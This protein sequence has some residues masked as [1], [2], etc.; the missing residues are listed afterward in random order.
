MLDDGPE[1]DGPDSADIVC[2][3]T[4]KEGKAAAD[5]S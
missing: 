3:I 2:E 1:E 5:G 4:E